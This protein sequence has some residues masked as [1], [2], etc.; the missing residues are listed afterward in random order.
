LFA[1][2][3]TTINRLVV[4]NNVAWQSQNFVQTVTDPLPG[5]NTWW[6]LAMDGGGLT[7][8]FGSIGSINNI[9]TANR[10]Q[11]SN[12]MQNYL[13]NYS[14]S[15]ASPASGNYNVTLADVRTALPNLTFGNVTR[16]CSTV[17]NNFLSVN[18]GS[19]LSWQSRTAVLYR[20]AIP[21]VPG[22]L[23]ALGAAA[24]FGFS[25]KLRKRINAGTNPASSTYSLS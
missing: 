21:A 24:A 8:A 11:M 10:I 13:T 4:Q 20:F 22:P 25:R 9:A 19:S 5:E 6:F 16:S 14:T 12:T 1:G 2:T 17:C 3:S 15:S 7:D 23:P 18:G